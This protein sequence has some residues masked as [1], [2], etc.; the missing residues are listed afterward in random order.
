M[1]PSDDRPCVRTGESPAIAG[2]RVMPSAAMS[3]SMWA[4][5]TDAK[6]PDRHGTVASAGESEVA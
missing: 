4:L 2:P 6:A 3:G 1:K 5:E